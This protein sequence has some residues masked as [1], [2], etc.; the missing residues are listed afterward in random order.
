[1]L[2][3]CQ[4]SWLQDNDSSNANGNWHAMELWQ[5]LVRSPVT[6][7]AS[8]SKATLCAVHSFTPWCNDITGPLTNMANKILPK[9]VTIHRTCPAIF[10]VKIYWPDRLTRAAIGKPWGQEFFIAIT[11]EAKCI[12]RPMFNFMRKEKKM[13]YSLTLSIK[14]FKNGGNYNF[15]I[16]GKTTDFI[17]N[18]FQN[19]VVKYFYYHVS[20]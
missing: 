13:Q 12:G 16:F 7:F 6:T 5:Y 15:G 2:L 9:E 17:A 8:R 11:W 4:S 1:M 18:Y 14:S 20:G 19:D 10:I 3:K